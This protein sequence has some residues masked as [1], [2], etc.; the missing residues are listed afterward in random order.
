M[1][2]PVLGRVLVVLLFF[3]LP[4]RWLAQVDTG[5]GAA[6][7]ARPTKSSSS[8]DDSMVLVRGE[9]PG[10]HD[11]SRHISRQPVWAF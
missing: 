5:A 8:P 3:W 11:F 1:D 10:Y 7:K 6:N 9:Q 2:T 4:S